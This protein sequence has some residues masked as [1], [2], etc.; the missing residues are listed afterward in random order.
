MV[1][2]QESAHF[3]Y[4]YGWSLGARYRTSAFNFTTSF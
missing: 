4:K 1:L 3:L 2:P